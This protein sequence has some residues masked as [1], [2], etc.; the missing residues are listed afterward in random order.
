[1]SNRA[2]V[3]IENVQKRYA[4]GFHALKGVSFEVAEGDFFA[5]LGPNGAGKTT[6]I[7]MM[8]GLSRPTEG[9]ISIMGHDVVTEPYVTRMLLG[10]VPQELVFDPFFSVYETLKFQSGYFG[11]RHNDKWIDEILENLGLAD[12]KH[13]NTRNLSGGMKRRLMV[14]QALVH[15]PPVIILDEPTA[16]VD[17]ELRQSL[18]KFITRLNKEGHTIILTTHYL[19]EAQN[20]CNRIAMLK[21]GE[22]IAL[23]ETRHLLHSQAGDGVRVQLSLGADLPE[24]LNDRVVGKVDRDYT[25][26]LKDYDELSYVL[27]TL[28]FSNV[29]IQNLLILETD[30]E[31]VFLKMMDSSYSKGDAIKDGV[32]N[33]AS[34]TQA[35]LE[36]KADDSDGSTSQEGEAESSEDGSK[37]SEE[38]VVEN[39]EKPHAESEAQSSEGKEG[40]DETYAG[41]GLNSGEVEDAKD[42]STTD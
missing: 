19:E 29:N 36:S 25:L 16:G 39:G 32:V 2:A 10:V 33:Q 9:K 26:K 21:T 42:K 22:L 17:V 28:H 40:A 4:N 8:A 30:L 15:K 14:G 23:D 24:I 7:S 27:R 37:A 6:L 18:W 13:T 5:L 41:E 20:L 3:K 38:K 1:M 11:I 12:K 34:G 35:K 31:A